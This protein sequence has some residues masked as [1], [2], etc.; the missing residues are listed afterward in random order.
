MEGGGN[1]PDNEV[2]PEFARIDGRDEGDGSN[3]LDAIIWNRKETY[4]LIES[5]FFFFAT[6]HS[7]WYSSFSLRCPLLLILAQIPRSNQEPRPKA[8]AAS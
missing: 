3:C 7:F 1:S 5:T 2:R 4:H 6:F 8:F